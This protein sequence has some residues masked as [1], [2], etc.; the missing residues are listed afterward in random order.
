MVT[1]ILTPAEATLAQV[2]AKYSLAR[3][4]VDEHF[5]LVALS[6]EQ[7][8]YTILVKDTV[9]ARLEGQNQVSVPYANPKI[10]PYGPKKP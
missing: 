10:E 1:L 3:D 5:G 2:R 4:E 7:N 9:A 6:P 8:L